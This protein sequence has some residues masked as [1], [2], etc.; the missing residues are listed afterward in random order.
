MESLELGFGANN[1]W[2]AWRVG[3]GA[4]VVNGT[5]A[6]LIRGKLDAHNW[7]APIVHAIAPTDAGLAAGTMGFLFIPIKREVLG[8]KALT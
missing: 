5:G 8:R 4:L 6:T 2:T 7:I 3:A 1:K